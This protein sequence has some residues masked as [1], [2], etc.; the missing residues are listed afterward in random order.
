MTSPQVVQLEVNILLVGK[1]VT[2]KQRSAL[3]CAEWPPADDTIKSNMH[4]KQVHDEPAVGQSEKTRGNRAG[5]SLSQGQLVCPPVTRA[6][7]P[8]TWYLIR[9]A[10][11]CCGERP[12]TTSRNTVW[13]RSA[14][15]KWVPE[16][17]VAYAY[18]LE[19]HPHDKRAVYT[20]IQPR[21][22][23]GVCL[24]RFC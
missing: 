6:P 7:N 10:C 13:R 18:T 23:L 4:P 19:G 11:G 12:V 15:P 20:P 3:I 16:F 24:L 17:A 21:T 22:T 5:I 14:S 8:S 2:P 9:T 1:S